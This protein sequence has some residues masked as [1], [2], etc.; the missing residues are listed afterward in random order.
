MRP[1]LLALCFLL[2]ATALPA[3]AQE[4]AWLGTG[5]LFV[6]DAFGDMQDRWRSGAYTISVMRGA[7]AT[8]ARPQDFGDLIEFRLADRILAPANIVAPAPGDRRYAGLLSLGLYSHFATRGTE[9]SLGSELV[10]SGPMTGVG[11][12]QTLAHR[13]LGSPEPSA[14]V[15]AAQFPNA[16][17]PTVAGEIARPLS[18][19]EGV[20]LR[21]FAA[22]RFGDE[23]LVRVGADLLIGSNFTTG[24]PVR[25]LTTGLLYQ[26]L[27]DVPSTGWSFLLGGDAARVFSSVWLPAP[28]YTLT[29][30]RTRLRAGVQYQ[31]ERVGVFY[32]VTWLGREFTAQSESQTL[33]ALQL[34]IRF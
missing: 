5:R 31:G 27:E 16:V 7:E 28:D 25:D 21:P 1:G 22:A 14:A 2:I 17:Y 10:A 6:N 24:V 19:G 34:Q 18:L 13:F 20:V 12:F 4:R 8:M 3:Q 33:G 32:G 11:R 9:I 26:T 15:L 29:D 23:T 30:L